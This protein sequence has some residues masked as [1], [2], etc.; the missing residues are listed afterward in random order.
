M[1][2]DSVFTSRRRG[3]RLHDKTL[4]QTFWNDSEDVDLHGH[5]I[6]QND[7]KAKLDFMVMVPDPLPPTM[8]MPGTPTSP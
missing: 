8:P 7:P 6:Y 5:I 3:L 4:V 2:F 1:E